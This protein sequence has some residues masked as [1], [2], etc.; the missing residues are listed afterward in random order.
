[1]DPLTA[2]GLAGNVIQFIDFS[3]KLF[4][5]TREIFISGACASKETLAVFVVTEDL[6]NL[7]GKLSVTDPQNPSEG[8]NSST[9]GDIRFIA[10]RCGIAAQELLG[11]LERVKTSKP[12][13][14][15]NSFKLCLKTVWNSKAIDEMEGN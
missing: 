2:I 11:A 5:Q 8:V 10:T 9:H 6:K 4:S 13:S 14:K 12:N 15:W 7:C 3:C 1:M